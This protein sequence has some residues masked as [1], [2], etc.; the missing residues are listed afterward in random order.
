M[1]SPWQFYFSAAPADGGA[2]R[3]GDFRKD[4]YHPRD[5]LLRNLR[6]FHFCTI[7]K[8][9]QTLPYKSSIR[10]GCCW[11]MRHEWKCDRDSFLYNFRKYTIPFPEHYKI[12]PCCI[13]SN[14]PLATKIKLQITCHMGAVVT[15]E[16]WVVCL[17][18]VLETIGAMRSYEHKFDVE[19]YSKDMG[20]SWLA[21]WMTAHIKRYIG[22]CIDRLSQLLRR[23]FTHNIPQ[24]TVRQS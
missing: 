18:Y 17:W 4:I 24:H 21:S 19:L 6:P 10:S 14:E 3:L 15:R 2:V 20:Q 16:P 11:F 23:C 7:D 1:A 9:R 13:Q 22:V 5:H 12:C 8:Q